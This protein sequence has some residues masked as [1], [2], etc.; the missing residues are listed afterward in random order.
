MAFINTATAGNFVQVDINAS[1]TFADANAAMADT[2]N[3]MSVPALQEITVNATPGLFRWK[4][5]DALSEFVVTTPST[6]S[7]NMTMVLDPTTFFTGEGSTAGIFDITND[8]EL[9]YF[10]MYWEGSS[11]G[12]NYIEGSGYLSALAPTVNP[13]SPVWVS[14]V[15]IEVVGNYVSGTVA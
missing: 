6:N 15:T 13:D 4:Q 3:V 11:S 9:V 5:L 2:A 8:K 1:G 7:V 10:R 14:P 12:D